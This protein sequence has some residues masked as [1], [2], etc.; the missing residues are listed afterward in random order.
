MKKDSLMI[1]RSAIAVMVCVISL[2]VVSVRAMDNF[3]PYRPPFFN[4]W[5]GEPRLIEPKMSTV[6]VMYGHGSTCKSRACGC[7]EKTSLLNLYG[8]FNMLKL[9]SFVPNKSTTNQEDIALIELGRT[10][11][12]DSFGM[13]KYHGRFTI[14][15]LHILWTQNFDHG[16][17]L[18]VDF[19]IRHMQLSHVCYE[20]LSP[21]DGP[22]PNI[23]TRTWQTFLKLYDKILA[24]YDLSASGFNHTALGDI[25]ASFG[26]GFNYQDT[27]VLDYVDMSLMVGMLF[28]SGRKKNIDCAFDMP[29]GYNGHLGFGT[30]AEL[31]IGVYNWLTFGGYAGAIAL[32]DKT[33]M[34]RLK[35]DMRQNGL[36]KL[37][38]GCANVERGVIY[39][40]GAY[41]K[42]D[43][44]AGG[45]SLLFGYSYSAQ[46]K[47]QVHPVNGC[48]F[49]PEAANCDDTLLGWGMH[50]LH[51][52]AD[53][54]FGI[55]KNMFSP[56]IGVFANAN[57]GGHRVFAT[58]VGG[59]SCGLDISFQC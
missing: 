19:P 46:N 5:I 48:M 6:D 20:D 53:Y 16:I 41:G 11:G 39:D 26:W 33:Y 13:L 54:D 36:I 35:T 34:V 45:F 47:D 12:R 21:K 18:Q 40:A 28:P 15:E 23:H 10:V 8:P 9:G 59:F 52:I 32:L 30:S 1:K 17:F 37:A 2:V 27:R 7:K 24:R 38:K 22:C 43:H 55:Y 3:H 14:D 44:F 42:L 31:S 56:R 49:D 58:N 57:V 4:L 25:S 51:F 29:S 50:T